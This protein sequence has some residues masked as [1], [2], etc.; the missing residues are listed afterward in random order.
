MIYRVFGPFLVPAGNASDDGS[1]FEYQRNSHRFGR[2]LLANQGALA[3]F[4][5]DLQGGWS[6]RQQV[7]EFVL[8]FVPTVFHLFPLLAGILVIATTAGD[9]LSAAAT[10]LDVASRM[11]KRSLWCSTVTTVGDV[12][13]AWMLA[14]IENPVDNLAVAM[15]GLGITTQSAQ[16]VVIAVPANSHR[17]IMTGAYDT[18]LPWA[19]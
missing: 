16:H 11:M 5:I 10:L 1:M 7:D 2:Q 19:F 14:A 15:E 9:G 6:E 13:P 8:V 12:T 4:G 17:F 3:R 18:D